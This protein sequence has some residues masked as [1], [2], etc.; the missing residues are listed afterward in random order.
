[1]CTPGQRQTADK[2]S[3][4][5]KTKS[6]KDSSAVL[7]LWI[8]SAQPNFEGNDK[9]RLLTYDLFL[10]KCALYTANILFFNLIER[11]VLKKQCFNCK[12]CHDRTSTV[13]ILTWNIPV[14]LSPTG[15]TSLKSQASLQ[16]AAL[17]TSAGPA[18]G[19]CGVEW[20]PALSPGWKS[21]CCGET[22]HRDG[23]VWRQAYRPQA[24]DHHPPELPGIYQLQGAHGGALC[25]SSNHY[26]EKKVEK[27]LNVSKHNT[28][29]IRDWKWINILS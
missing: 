8:N 1:M 5:I 24:L 13:S 29:N 27:E 21:R 11:R 3:F 23:L 16:K 2:A 7:S 15:P 9:D 22:G 20:C 10:G 4:S 12:N 17:Q 28:T 14:S 6:L 19:Q 26:S 18:C 25:S